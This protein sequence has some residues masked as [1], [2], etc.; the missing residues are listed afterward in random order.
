MGPVIAE[1]G[2][3]VKQQRRCKR[4]TDPAKS[5]R[6]L[7]IALDHK[8]SISKAGTSLICAFEALLESKKGKS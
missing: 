7:V 6:Y 4:S 3:V 8:H 5:L 2:S 1:R